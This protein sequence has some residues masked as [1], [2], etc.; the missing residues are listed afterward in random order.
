MYARGKVI[1]YLKYSLDNNSNISD[2]VTPNWILNAQPKVLSA[3]PSGMMNANDPKI[4]SP[5]TTATALAV[6]IS[7]CESTVI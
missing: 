6:V 1:I 3:T 7:V 4:L 2:L 5:K